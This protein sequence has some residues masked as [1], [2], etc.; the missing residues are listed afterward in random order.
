MLKEIL[1][2][3]RKQNRMKRQQNPLTERREP[4]TIKKPVALKQPQVRNSQEVKLPV[5]GNRVRNHGSPS[6]PRLRDN[7]SSL[8]HVQ[9]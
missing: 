8:S 2:N 3:Q 7:R 1:A 5:V 9:S 4:Q 6:K